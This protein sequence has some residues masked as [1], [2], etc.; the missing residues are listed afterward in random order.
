MNQRLLSLVTVVTL[1]AT[2]P[3]VRADATVFAEL[4]WSGLSWTTTG[5]LTVSL[6]TVSTSGPLSTLTSRDGFS[7]NFTELASYVQ[8][9][10]TATLINSTAVQSATLASSSLQYGL[11]G[12]AYRLSVIELNGSGTVTLQLPY[13]FRLTRDGD[14][15]ARGALAASILQTQQ[16]FGYEAVISPSSQYNSGDPVQSGVISFSLDGNGAYASYFMVSTVMGQIQPAIPEP[17]SWAMMAM[18]GGLLLALRRKQRVADAISPQ[19][20]YS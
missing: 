5:D 6:Q 1:S 18:G 2:S 14:F 7:W 11:A 15:L 12:D 10:Q 16:A 8:S 13:E 3:H 20:V 9:D 4:D 19:V 17:E